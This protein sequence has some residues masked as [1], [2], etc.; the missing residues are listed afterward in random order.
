MSQNRCM[1]AD[2][3]APGLRERKKL[4]TRRHIRQCAMDLFAAKGYS[5]TTV[6]DIA[7]AADV[8]PRTFFRY[9]PS[10]EMVVVADD[11]DAPMLAA[12]DE[13]PA[14][15]PVLTAVCQAAEKTIAQAS[16]DEW[17]I[18][19]AR[20]ELLFSEPE[21][22]SALLTELWRTIDM[23]AEAVAK[24]TGRDPDDFEVRVLAGAVMGA[25][26]APHERSVDLK[27]SARAVRFLEAG[28]PL[29]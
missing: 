4:Q 22:R 1:P 17:A 12:L 13:Q 16:D 3:A 9:F 27:E 23:I 7:A 6:D 21:L 15:L 11:M 10:K 19:R 2:D 28:L 20:T 5:Q 18:N 8:S 29:D 26:I 25:T 24:R 14:D